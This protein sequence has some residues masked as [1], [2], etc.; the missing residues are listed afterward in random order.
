MNERRDG[1]T[2]HNRREKS[3]LY[4]TIVNNQLLKALTNWEIWDEESCSDHSV[5]KFYTG[6][7]NKT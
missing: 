2:F 3:N 7:C 5:I 1:T 6:Q 4:L